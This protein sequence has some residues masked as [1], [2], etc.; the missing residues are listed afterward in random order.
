MAGLADMRGPT[1]RDTRR[2]GEHP[3]E[4]TMVRVVDALARKRVGSVAAP[5][6]MP[7]E[8]ATFDLLHAVDRGG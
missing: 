4:R 7:I 5:R 2:N 1:C 8:W 6:Q 3:L